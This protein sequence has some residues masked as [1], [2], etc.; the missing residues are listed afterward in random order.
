MVA[1]LESGRLRQLDAVLVDAVLGEL[2]IRLSTNQAALA[3][4]DRQRQRDLVHARCCGYAGRHLTRYG[5]EVR[6]E[7]EVGGGRTRGWIDLLAY[8]EAD[9]GLFCPE[10]KTEL[11][12]AGAVQRTLSW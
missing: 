6:H 5:W 7:V 3:L 2:G 12:D 1:R 10:L 9:G 11:N 8:R 4:A